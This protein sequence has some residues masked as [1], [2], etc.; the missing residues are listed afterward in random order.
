MQ[1]DY[2]SMTNTELVDLLSQYTMKVTQ[3]L[4]ERKFNE[5]YKENKNVIQ[6]IILEIERRKQ[7]SVP[8]TELNVGEPD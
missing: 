8:G 2:S 3:L 4:N 5:E 7:N 6:Q 1:A